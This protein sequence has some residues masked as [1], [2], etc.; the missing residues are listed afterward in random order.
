M[1]RHARSTLGLALLAALTLTGC[2]TADVGE[3]EATPVAT[4]TSTMY[5]PDLEQL[6]PPPAGIID[7]KT[8]QTTGPKAPAVWD[9]TSRA[10]AVS[11]AET[12][13]TAYARPSVDPNTWIEDL[14]PL[15]TPKAAKDYNFIRN[16]NIPATQVTGP[17]VIVNDDSVYLAHVEVP[18]DAGTWTVMIVREYGDSPWLV[19]RFTPPEGIH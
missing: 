13:M 6:T 17:G 10:A 2:G 8:G 11:A 4:P 1:T 12:A 7:D 19:E 14:T 18:T 3:S 15:L 5:V 16:G 9:E